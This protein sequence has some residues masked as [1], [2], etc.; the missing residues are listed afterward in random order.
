MSNALKWQVFVD[1]EMTG[2][3]FWGGKTMGRWKNHPI[4]YMHP[5]ILQLQLIGW[6]CLRLGDWVLNM[7]FKFSFSSFAFVTI[8]QDYYLVPLSTSL[9]YAII[10]PLQQIL[11]FEQF[12]G[13]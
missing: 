5:C 10:L 11:E 9:N 1:V 7:F 3:L 2:D 6:I 4:T 12:V 8:E 13:P